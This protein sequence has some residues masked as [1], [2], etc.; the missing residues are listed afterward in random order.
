MHES[1]SG[2][3]YPHTKKKKKKKKKNNA[4]RQVCNLGL[5]LKLVDVK[6]HVNCGC[7]I[8]VVVEC[9]KYVAVN[10]NKMKKSTISNVAE[11]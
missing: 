3:K 1:Y 4:A 11:N 5:T 9:A 2:G 7:K 10:N 6:S 8:V